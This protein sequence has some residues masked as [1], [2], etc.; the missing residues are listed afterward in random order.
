MGRTRQVNLQKGANSNKTKKELD[1]STQK[2][3]K[4]GKMPKFQ[5]SCNNPFHQ[6]WSKREREKVI[7][8]KRHGFLAVAYAFEKYVEAKLKKSRYKIN[9]L[10]TTCLEMSLRKRKLTKFLP[11]NDADGLEK[12][13]QSQVRRHVATKPNL[14]C[15]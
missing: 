9:N 1:S 5:R 8:L 6:A 11:K 12:K 7:S 14:L 4:V 10:C 13:I 15:C 2:H 3:S